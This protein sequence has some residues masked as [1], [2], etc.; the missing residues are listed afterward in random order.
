MQPTQEKIQ[1]NQND[2]NNLSDF[3]KSSYLVSSTPTPQN[4]I[5]TNP[6]N[7]GISM[8]VDSL[9]STPQVK[10]P[11][12]TVQD[13]TA[14]GVIA[15]TQPS[16]QVAQDQYKQVQ[17]ATGTEAQDA[18]Q[19]LQKLALNVFGQKADV[20][21]NQVN[22]ENQAG[23]QEQQ[24]VLGEINTS[25]ANEQVALRNEQE[26]I[27]Q[28]YGTE[29]QKQISQNTLNDTY[30]RRLADLAIRQ[31]AANQNITAI[32][33]NADRQTKLLTAPLDTKIAYLST[34]GKDN[35]DFLSKEQ[36]NKLAFI[37]N[38]LESQKKDIE[39][40]QNAKTQMITEIA[41]NGG[42]TNQELIRQIQ[43]AK[44]AGEVTTLG[45]NSG[46]IGKEQRLNNALDR[47][48][49]QAQIGKIYQ[50]MAETRATAEAKKAGL[51]LTPVS[52]ARIQQEVS[53]INDLTKSK[54]IQTAVG[55]SILSRSPSG[56]G[57][58]IGKA[59]SIVGAGGLVRDA[60]LKLSGDT[61]NFI[62]GVEQLKE[63]ATLDKLT[64]AK[65]S[66]ATFGALSDGERQTLAAAA[67]K[68]GTWTI[69]DSDG[70]TVGYNTTEK[71]IKNELDTINNFKKLD[72]IYRGGNIA[73]VGVI[74]TPDGHYATQNSDGTYTILK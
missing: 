51:T 57:G 30:G 31:S 64:E 29:A 21:A 59:L 16:V 25:I 14:T 8:T 27:R 34:F 50:D 60:Q 53:N 58:V 7:T 37:T 26:K 12:Q 54:G 35:V 39:T 36:Q 19:A 11:Q 43:N 40:L 65:A 62:A 24:K 49:K 41:N 44:T 13:T 28:G 70:A 4:N 18:N 15:S 38:N 71:N 17:Q 46:Y 69:K 9:Q 61:Q 73:D 42:G 2:Y 3:A 55:T 6:S 47:Q 22:L 67:S 56:I 66:G 10:V 33:E 68:L 74:Q 52:A 72:Y 48:Y 23:L 32:R 1:V 5:N 63:Q 45:A 20:Q